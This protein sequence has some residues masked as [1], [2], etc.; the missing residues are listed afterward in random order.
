MT[1]GWRLLLA[2]CTL[3]AA[4][5]ACGDGDDDGGGGG[6]KGD[7]EA[8]KQACYGMCLQQEKGQD[9]LTDMTPI[10]KQGCDLVA[11]G[12]AEKC[13][14]AALA[15]YDCNDGIDF[16]CFLGAPT[17][18]DQTACE[19]ENAAMNACTGAK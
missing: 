8:L 19:A 16:L 2:A 1:S 6:K 15:Y 17:A 13:P 10:C 14:E 4:P 7:P 3:L 18:K 9:C 11:P 12:L 5:S